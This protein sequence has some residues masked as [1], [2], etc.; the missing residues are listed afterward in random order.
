MKCPKSAV[1]LCSRRAFLYLVHFLGGVLGTLFYIARGEYYRIS[2]IHIDLLFAE[3]PEQDREALLRA[4]LRESGK[5][6]AEMMFYWLFPCNLFCN[7]INSVSGEQLIEEARSQGRGVILVCPHLGNW[8]IFN[9]YAGQLGVATSYKP[10][11]V[12]WLDRRIFRCREKHGSRMVPLSTSGIR[13]LLKELEQGKIIAVFPDQ[14]PDGSGQVVVPYFGQPA[15]T[16]VMVSRLLQKTNAVVL[17]SFAERLSHGRGYDIHLLPVSTEVYSQDLEVS[18]AAL[19]KEMEACVRRCP[20]QYIWEYK[21]FKHTVAPD[22]Y[23]KQ[24]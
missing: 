24:A 4:S 5:S 1:A 20:E 19:N 8:E 14:L 2:R 15:G 23:R 22:L 10:I 12:E 18:A 11:K 16:G 17:C 9:M 3:K 6:I 7:L 21:R 13:S